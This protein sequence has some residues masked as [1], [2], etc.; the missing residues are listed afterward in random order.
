MWEYLCEVNPDLLRQSWEL[1]M[2]KFPSMRLR[3]S[4]REE[5]VQ[6]IDKH[7]SVDWRYSDL[8]GGYN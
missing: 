1:C 2:D 8:S 3:F 7:S 5:L 6:V 4:W